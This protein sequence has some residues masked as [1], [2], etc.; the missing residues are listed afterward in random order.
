M[1]HS[2]IKWEWGRHG[3]QRQIALGLMQSVE[4]HGVNGREQRASLWLLGHLTLSF[5]GLVTG[6]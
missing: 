5:M 2:V 4:L 6:Y 3:T 1:N